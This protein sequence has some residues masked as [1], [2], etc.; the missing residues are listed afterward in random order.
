MSKAGKIK[1]LVRQEELLKNFEGDFYQEKKIG[2]KW[3]VKMYNRGTDRWQVA[4]YSEESFAKYKEFTANSER[5]KHL[6][7]K[8]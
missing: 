3:Y 6:I 1:R 2:Y 7:R 8:E 5:L 4:V